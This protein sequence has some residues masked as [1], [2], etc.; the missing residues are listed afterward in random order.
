MIYVAIGA[1]LPDARGQP[2]L[3]ACRDA[4]RAIAALPGVRLSALSRWYDSAPEPAG[5][6]PRFINGVAALDGAG[7]PEGLLGALQRIE[8][9]A[10]RVRGAVN[11][12]RVLDLDIVDMHGLVRPAPDPVLPHPR[13]HLRGFVLYPLRDVAP[14]WVHPVWGSPIDDLIAGLPP[15]DI[16]ALPD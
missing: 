15:Q 11:A 3:Q 9:A 1:N 13:A 5:D 10:G 4:V 6:Q 7:T 8:A 16:A 12:A 2:P 14:G